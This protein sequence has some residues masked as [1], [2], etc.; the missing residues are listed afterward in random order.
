MNQKSE[1]TN[2]FK[3][4]KQYGVVT[5]VVGCD[6]VST[7]NMEGPSIQEQVIRQVIKTQDEHVRKALIELGWTPPPVVSSPSYEQAES[8]M[9]RK[10]QLPPEPLKEF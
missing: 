2:N 6:I 3:P 5:A 4:L 9:H 8:R 7:I 10:G 1:L